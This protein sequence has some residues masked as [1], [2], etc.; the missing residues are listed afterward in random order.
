LE[1][2]GGPYR[3]KLKV[4]ALLRDAEW[5]CSAINN[6]SV[7]EKLSVIGD[8]GVEEWVSSCGEVRS[9]GAHGREIIHCVLVDPTL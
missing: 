9:V 5:S 3:R 4:A 6:R 2:P 7:I 1:K 8:F